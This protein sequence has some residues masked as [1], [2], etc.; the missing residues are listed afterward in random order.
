MVPCKEMNLHTLIMHHRYLSKEAHIAPW[1][2]CP[3]LKPVVEHIAEEVH[4]T[5]LT[6]DRL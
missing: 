2:D 4:R 3:I 1:D 6:L 5:S